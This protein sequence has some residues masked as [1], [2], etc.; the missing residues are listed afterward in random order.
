MSFK[1]SFQIFHDCKAL[2]CRAIWHVCADDIQL[3]QCQIAS[4]RLE[5]DDVF[6][7]INGMQYFFSCISCV[8]S[9]ARS[10]QAQRTRQSTANIAYFVVYRQT[11][12]CKEQL[13]FAAMHDHDM[14]AEIS[15]IRVRSVD[16][17]RWRRDN[18]F[19]W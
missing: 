11:A 10:S 19:R 1:L 5:L 9:N 17:A 15:L 4:K 16:L 2:S 7:K 12:A 18:Y 8:A 13:L 6:C 14:D 3:A